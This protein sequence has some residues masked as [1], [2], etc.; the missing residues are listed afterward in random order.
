M[1]P[2]GLLH[3]PEFLTSFHPL[4]FLP[5]PDTRTDLFPQA[6]TPETVNRL[7]SQKDFPYEKKS[8]EQL[9]PF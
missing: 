2:P 7:V 1:H 5:R 9:C 4:V 3:A 8:H 6:S